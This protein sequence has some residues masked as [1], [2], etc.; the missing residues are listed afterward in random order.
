MLTSAHQTQQ[1]RVAIA[2]TVINADT[3]EGLPQVM[4]RI[5]QAPM[6]CIQGFLEILERS[7]VPHPHLM[8]N[9]QRLMCDRPIT[10]D[11]LKLAQVLFKSFERNQWLAAPRPDQTLTGGDG[12]Y[13]F[14]DL[15]PG[16]YSLSATLTI[17]HGCQGATRGQVRVHSSNQ[18]L[19][20]SEL[21]LTLSLRPCPIS[22][23]ATGL[24]DLLPWPSWSSL[25]QAQAAFS[26]RV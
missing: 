18:W 24:E 1:Q 25:Q 16:D 14:F 10:P 22:I 21:D 26:Q 8:A 5:T 7:L 11:T 15:P 3:Q 2:G 12:H 17:P 4:V 6:E 19:A 13:C 20:F 23:P 9:Y